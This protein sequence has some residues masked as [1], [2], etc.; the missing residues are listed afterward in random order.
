MNKKK[1]INNLINNLDISLDETN[2]KRHTIHTGPLIRREK[3]YSDLDIAER[4]KIFSKLFHFTRKVDIKYQNII[5]N[6]KQTKLITDINNKISKQLSNIVKENLYYFQKFD[7][8]IIYYDDGQLPLANILISVFTSWFQD[9]FEYRVVNPQEYKLFQTADLIC[10][11]SLIEHKLNEGKALSASEIKFFRSPRTLKINYLKY[12]KK[13]KF[14][15]K[16]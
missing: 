6:K 2:L 9:K 4:Y 13:I 11:L 8:I 7:K 15:Y 12:L 16:N 3:I 14:H 1:Q 5:V 10:T